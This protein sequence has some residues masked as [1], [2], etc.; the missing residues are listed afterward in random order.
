MIIDTHIKDGSNEMMN[1]PYYEV[2]KVYQGRYL[3]DSPE[4][5]F[6]VKWRGYTGKNAYSWEPF[7]H[8]STDLQKEIVEQKQLK[9]T[10]K[11][12]AKVDIFV[13]NSSTR[14]FLEQ[15]GFDP[16]AGGT[17]HPD[18][19]TRGDVSTTT[20]PLTHSQEVNVDKMAGKTRSKTGTKLLPD[21][22]SVTVPGTFT[23]RDP[24]TSVE[25]EHENINEENV[26]VEETGDNGDKIMRT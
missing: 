3:K 7:S 14:E 2:E 17:S 21:A 12:F 24:I 22:S 20:L 9:M 16:N 15:L 10:N 19:R 23:E 26:E 1:K 11:K 13:D 5:Q 18:V 4:P 8:L 6:K 25:F